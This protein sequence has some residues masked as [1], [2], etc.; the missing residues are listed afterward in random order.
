MRRFLLFVLL[1]LFAITFTGQ[2]QFSVDAHFRTR[3]EIRDGYRK[4]LP[5]DAP[6]AFH[7]LQR[8]RLSVSYETD[9]FKLRFTPQDARVWGDEQIATSTGVFGDYSS[10]DMFEG[11]VELRLGKVGWLSVG[12]QPFKYDNERMLATRRWNNTGLSY[13]AL[14][15]KL[16]LN[17][18]Y[19]HV[20]GSW[21]SKKEGISGYQ[22]PSGRIKTLNFLWLNKTFFEKANTSFLHILS[23]RTETDS[24]SKLHFK[25]TTGIYSQYRGDAIQVAGNAYVQYGKNNIGQKT[26]AYLID[27]EGSFTPAKIKPAVGFSYLSGNAKTGQNQQTNRLFDVLYGARHKFFGRM[28]YFRNF[29]KHTNEGGIADYYLKLEYHPVKTISIRNTIHY[30]QLAQLN[31]LTPGKKELGYENN[32]I[33]NYRFANG[34]TIRTGFFFM[35]PAEP[36]EQIQGV[37]SSGLQYFYY[38]QLNVN[39]TLF[40]KE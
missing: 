27:M 22:Y 31:E 7:V 16:K 28:D 21:N 35:I 40:A 12:R 30:L 14:R 10:L 24:T 32:F 38:L 36:M 17:D 13:D 2:A 11:Y 8:T 5:Q 29:S 33:L 4:L 39:P 6:V 34:A 37:K 26:R 3:L 1:F 19:V 20:A 15:F 25:Q 18:W 23:G 9:D